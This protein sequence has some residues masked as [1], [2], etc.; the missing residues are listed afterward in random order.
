MKKLILLLLCLAT[1]LPVLAEGELKQASLK[2]GETVAWVAVEG[3]ETDKVAIGPEDDVE[4]LCPDGDWHK[5]E[6]EILEEPVMAMVQKGQTLGFLYVWDLQGNELNIGLVALEELDSN[7]AAFFSKYGIYILIMLVLMMAMLVLYF[8]FRK[9][10]TAYS[11]GQ[12]YKKQEA[13]KA[14]RKK[15]ESRQNKRIL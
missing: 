4:F 8:K 11:R 9:E 6:I 14:A 13:R 5:A 10:D 1:A 2:K 15:N 12:K 7:F 3:S